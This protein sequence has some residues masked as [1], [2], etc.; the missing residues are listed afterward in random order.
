M[1]FAAAMA[2][3]W[4]TPTRTALDVCT[5]DFCKPTYPCAPLH[6][7]LHRHTPALG[8]IIIITLAMCR[9]TQLFVEH[10]NVSRIAPS[11]AMAGLHQQLNG[12]LEGM[13]GHR[14]AWGAFGGLQ[15]IN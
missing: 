13:G 1:R 10:P 3:H 14:R 12:P 8:I 6:S 15:G 5:L 4:L 7:S 11:Q 9:F 2:W